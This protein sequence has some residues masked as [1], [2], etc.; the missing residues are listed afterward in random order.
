MTVCRNPPLLPPPVENLASQVLGHG[1]HLLHAD[2][3]PAHHLHDHFQESSSKFF[4]HCGITVSHVW[5]W[6]PENPGVKS[7]WNIQHHQHRVAIFSITH[8]LSFCLIRMYWSKGVYHFFTPLL[9]LKVDQFFTLVFVFWIRPAAEVY[10]LCGNN[11]KS[12]LTTAKF[13][14]QPCRRA[15]FEGNSLIFIS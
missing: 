4:L 6:M 9:D 11:W 3:S 15:L 14:L 12:K 5:F 1:L 10:Y 7:L 8:T 2:L 13:I